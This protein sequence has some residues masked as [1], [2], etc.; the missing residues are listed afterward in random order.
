MNDSKFCII[1]V[2]PNSWGRGQTIKEATRNLVKAG[3]KAKDCCLRFVLNDDKA[4]VDDMGTLRV[5]NENNNVE[6]FKI[7]ES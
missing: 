5:H 2:S 7:S 6:S 1:A 4:Y 3:G